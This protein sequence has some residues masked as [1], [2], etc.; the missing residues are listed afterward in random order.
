VFDR[1]G[2]VR[3]FVRDGAPA[4]EIADDIKRLLG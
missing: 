2:H 3:L 1:D 4:E